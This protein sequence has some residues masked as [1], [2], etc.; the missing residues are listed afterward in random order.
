[1]FTVENL[2]LSVNFQQMHWNRHGNEG[3]KGTGCCLKNIIV[4]MREK[5][6][7]IKVEKSLGK[8]SYAGKCSHQCLCKSMPSSPTFKF[9]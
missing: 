6:P 3:V 2:F 8:N 5:K 9:F 4:F 7:K 1:M